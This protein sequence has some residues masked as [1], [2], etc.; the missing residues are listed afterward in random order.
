MKYLQP[1]QLKHCQKCN[2]WLQSSSWARHWKYVH[3][4]DVPSYHIPHYKDRYEYPMGGMYC[5]VMG[6][7]LLSVLI[8]GV[9]FSFFLIFDTVM[10]NKR[11]YV[12]L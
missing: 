4:S 11:V 12:L 5:K 6:L 9:M 7:V 8:F 10:W 3:G 1:T 2:T